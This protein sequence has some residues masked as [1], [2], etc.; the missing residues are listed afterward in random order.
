M[1]L[2]PSDPQ[3]IN[4]QEEGIHLPSI[5]ELLDDLLRRPQQVENWFHRTHVYFWGASSSTSADDSGNENESNNSS[6]NISSI[7]GIWV[8]EGMRARSLRGSRNQGPRVKKVEMELQRAWNYLERRRN[9]PKAR[10]RWPLLMRTARQ[11]GD[12][13]A[14]RRSRNGDGIDDDKDSSQETFAGF[15]L[16]FSHADLAPCNHHNYQGNQSVP[17]F[18]TCAPV[19]CNHSFPFPNYATIQD[20]RPTSMDW[21]AAFQRQAVSHSWERKLRQIVWRGTLNGQGNTLMNPSPR[22]Q[23]GMWAWERR[24]CTLHDVGVYKVPPHKNY[25]EDILSRILTKPRI[26]FEDFSNYRAI[27]DIDG[28]AWSSRF[29]KLLCTNSIVV[30]VEPDF[31]DYFY[32]YLEPWKHYI[33]VRHDLSDLMDKVEW[34]L[35]SSNEKSVREIVRQANWWCRAHMTRPRIIVDM[36]DVLHLYVSLLD[37]GDPGWPLVWA[38]AKAKIWDDPGSGWKMR[39]LP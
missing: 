13:G 36:L 25:S 23:L 20:S 11:G 9:D 7:R 6:I 29:G 15:P 18:T 16:I 27:L 21:D 4:N 24:N 8:S 39:K 19:H 34:V 5:L 31:V 10:E 35:D 37:R 12:A 26:P 14:K 17:V 2:S 32:N 30:K 1:P 22:V 38:R 3:N 33:P 28:N